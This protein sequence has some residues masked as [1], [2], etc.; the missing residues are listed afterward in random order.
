MRRYTLHFLLILTTVLLLATAHAAPP[1]GQATVPRSAKQS[2][3]LVVFSIVPAQAEP[4][5]QVLLAISGLSDGLRLA[6]GG[7]ELAWR[8]LNDR[9]IA[10]DIPR[11]AAPGQYSLTVTAPDGASRSYAFTVLPLKPVAISID[12]DRVTSC[13]SGSARDVTIQGRNFNASSQL[14]FDGAIIRSRVSAPDT[15]KFTA[16]NVRDGLHQVAVKNGDISS[17]PLGLSIV[18]APDI[19]SITT[20]NDHVNSYEL[21]IEGDNFLQTSSVLVDGVRVEGNNNQQRDRLIYQDCTR[22][23]YERHPYSS[24]PKELRIQVVNPGGATSRTVLVTAP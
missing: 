5:T 1:P 8:V 16:P 19:T 12:P 9:R 24:S 18:T 15:I 7:D 6:L 11:D 22:M 3:S 4:G 13:T 20:G 21:I 2:G 17:T 14:L 10:F 23:I